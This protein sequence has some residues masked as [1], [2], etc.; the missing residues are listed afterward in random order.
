MI[1][2]RSPRIWHSR[3]A[4]VRTDL[5]GLETVR[6]PDAPT[7]AE[8]RARSEYLNNAFP[9]DDAGNEALTA[10]IA[11]AAPLV[12][13]LTGRIIAGTEGEE[14]P[15]GLLPIALEATAMKTAQLQAALGTVEDVEDAIDR[16]RIKSIAAGSCWQPNGRIKQRR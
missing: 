8:I 9:D 5:R 4:G 10:R 1:H 3:C 7:A 13:S 15:D 2:I 6:A 11:V 16:S 12:G 14:V